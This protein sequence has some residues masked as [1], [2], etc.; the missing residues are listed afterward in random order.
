MRTNK[1][2]TRARL[3][4]ISVNPCNLWLIS[5]FQSTPETRLRT[6]VINTFIT[7]TQRMLVEHVSLQPN[8]RVEVCADSQSI[9]TQRALIDEHFELDALEIEMNPE[10]L[11]SGKR[12]SQR[13]ESDHAPRQTPVVFMCS[14]RRRCFLQRRPMRLSLPASYAGPIRKPA[15]TDVKFLRAET[16]W[17]NFREILQLKQDFAIGPFAITV[18]NCFA[19]FVIL[20]QRPRSDSLN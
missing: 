10:E 15:Q 13:L 9:A 16:S 6:G 7:R 3:I 20:R 1:I 19:L 12:I 14:P 17:T 8:L 18:D 4:Q 5:S 2:T 11:A